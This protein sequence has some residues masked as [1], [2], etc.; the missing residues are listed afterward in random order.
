MMVERFAVQRANQCDVVDTRGDVRQE[1]RDFH[2]APAVATKRT[3]TAH[4][5]GR[6]LLDERK[7]HLV[8]HR[9]RQLLTVKLVELGLGVEQI[10]LARRAGHEQEDAILGFRSEMRPLRGKRIAGV[11]RRRQDV[12]FVQQGSQR[13]GTEPTGRRGQKVA[14][15]PVDV[16][17]ERVHV[18]TRIKVRPSTPSP[19]FATRHRPSREYSNVSPRSTNGGRS[20]SGRSN[21][22]TRTAVGMPPDTH[23]RRVKSPAWRAFQG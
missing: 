7:P 15:R 2:A 11:R 18:H 3:R 9:V 12:V 22:P 19:I 17:R 23:R 1:I 10:E 6:V 8:G 13:D 5:D 4:Q 20:P 21:M 14:A 16:F